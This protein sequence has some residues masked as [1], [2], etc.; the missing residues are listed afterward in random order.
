[1]PKPLMLIPLLL[2][3]IS[4]TETETDVPESIPPEH[5]NTEHEALFQKEAA[6]RHTLE[7]LQQQEQ[8]DNAYQATPAVD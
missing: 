5:F 4:C 1:M 6:L 7:E 2:A 8:E 3:C